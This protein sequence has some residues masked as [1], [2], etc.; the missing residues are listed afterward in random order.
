[1]TPIY[2]DRWQSH[3]V[4]V[5]ALS[6]SPFPGHDCNRCSWQLTGQMD[7]L[8]GGYW[9]TRRLPTCRLVMSRTGHLVDA[10]SV[11]S[12]LLLWVF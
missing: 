1:M 7:Q 11:S 3:R 12:C 6:W 4:G 10:T 5:M 2:G 8:S 9:K